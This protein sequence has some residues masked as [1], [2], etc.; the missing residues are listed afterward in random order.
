MDLQLLEA[1]EDQ[2]NTR[3]FAYNWVH[4]TNC[5]GVGFDYHGTGIYRDDGENL[6]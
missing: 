4:D 6:W 2:R 5:Q 1:P 3:A